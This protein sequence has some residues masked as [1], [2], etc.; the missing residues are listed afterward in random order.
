MSKA[1]RPVLL[2]GATPW[3]SADETFRN[4]GPIVGDLALGLTDGEFGLP[5]FWIFYVFVNTWREHPDLDVVRMPKGIS[6]MPDWVPTGYDD[7]PWVQLKAGAHAL[8]PI[9]T[10]GY[11]EQARSSYAKFCELRDA[12]VIPAGVRFQQSLPFPDDAA[13][14]FTN[15]P[16]T[17]DLMTVAYTDVLERDIKR[18]CELIPHEDLVI[19]WDINWET[20]AL[21][22]GD[23]MPGI[24]PMQFAPT[25]PALDRYT[26]YVRRLSAASDR[27]RSSS[28]S[29]RRTIRLIESLMVDIIWNTGI[30]ITAVTVIAAVNIAIPRPIVAL[31][32]VFTPSLVMPDPFQG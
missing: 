29:M 21:E 9:E 24:P 26:E 2:V 19:Q 8:S 14:L 5:R 6:G 17:F 11:P 1:D 28:F 7:M 18:L 23:Y 30:W 20:I 32:F 25:R 3:D 27:S 31:P 16:A 13:R 15:D 10:L 12:G 4:A 22:H